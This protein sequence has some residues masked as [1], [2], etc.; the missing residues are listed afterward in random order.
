MS[1]PTSY[2][3]LRTAFNRGLEVLIKKGIQP[4][5]KGFTT[6]IALPKARMRRPIN[7]NSSTLTEHYFTMALAVAFNGI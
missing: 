6:R 5:L 1:Q 3:P 2:A 7:T 4:V